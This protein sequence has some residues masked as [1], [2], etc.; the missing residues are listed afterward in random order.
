M[1]ESF[2][3]HSL[4]FKGFYCV[5]VSRSRHSFFSKLFNMQTKRLHDI[6]CFIQK[7]VVTKFP[8]S[9]YILRLVYYLDFSALVKDNQDNFMT[10]PCSNWRHRSI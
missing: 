3:Q 1:D 4:L 10:L 6:F 8:F 9:R 7:F 2:I 5:F